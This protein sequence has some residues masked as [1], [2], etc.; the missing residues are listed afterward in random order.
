METKILKSK[1]NKNQEQLAL[2]TGAASGIGYYLA[3]LLAKGGYNLMLVDLDEKKLKS[4]KDHI[5][6][7]YSVDVRILVKNLSNPSAAIDIAEALTDES[8]DVLVNNAGFGLFGRFSDTNWKRESDML[9]LHVIITTH[10]TKL[11]LKGMVSRGHGKILNV[12][13]LAAF[14]PGPL[15]SIYYASKAYLLS[16]SEAIAKEL[17]GT[18]VTVTALCPGPTK[19]GFQKAVSKTAI[20]NRI[21][22]NMASAKAVAKYG[23]DAMMN[24]KTVAIP[25]RMNKLLANLPRFI[26][27]NLV[28][29]IVKKIQEKNRPE[30]IRSLAS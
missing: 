26:P 29:S 3:K 5:Q 1:S 25:G 18:G 24:G 6:E 8:I 13:S 10:L 20:K 14:Q 17:K 7:K 27:R 15:M 2:I 16:F 22:V 28:T 12:S 30:K 21:R 9:N 11:I 4:A 19:T 23:Y